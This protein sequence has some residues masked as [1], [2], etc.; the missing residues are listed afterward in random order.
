M[1]NDDIL[2]KT[3]RKST[4][5]T[6]YEYNS[7]ST[8]GVSTSA[9]EGYTCPMNAAGHINK[10]KCSC[11]HSGTC[12]VHHNNCPI[13]NGSIN[14]DSSSNSGSG[15]AAYSG[16]DCLFRIMPTDIYNGIFLHAIIIHGEHCDLKMTIEYND[17]CA[18]EIVNI[19]NFLVG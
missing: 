13:Q 14:N 2:C 4:L 1:V 10:H 15:N 9:V 18:N 5:T 6:N 8:I 17:K 12:T 3:P 11:T 19:I 7:S 16:N